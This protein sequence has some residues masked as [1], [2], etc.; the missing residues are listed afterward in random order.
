MA[1]VEVPVFVAF[2]NEASKICLD[3]EIGPVLS[4]TLQMKIPILAL[5]TVLAEFQSKIGAVYVAPT[6]VGS[7]ELG[8]AEPAWAKCVTPGPAAAVPA[9]ASADFAGESAIPKN[10]P[11]TAVPAPA[12]ADPAGESAIPKYDEWFEKRKVSFNTDVD[13]NGESRFIPKTWYDA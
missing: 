1:A 8:S 5:V 13:L 7:A 4:F 9:P 6:R 3:P 2:S 12:S 11:A 10:D